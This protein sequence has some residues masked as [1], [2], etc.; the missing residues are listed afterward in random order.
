M[1]LPD[2]LTLIDGATL[3]CWARTICSRLVRLV[4]REITLFGASTYPDTFFPGMCRFIRDY[5]LDFGSIVGHTLSHTDGPE[6][7]R[8]AASGKLMFRFD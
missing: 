4:H 5:T 6:A 2:Y 8:L 7:F 3:D 1:R